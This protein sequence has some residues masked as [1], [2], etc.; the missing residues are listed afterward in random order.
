MDWIG[1]YQQPKFYPLDEFKAIMLKKYQ[2]QWEEM[3]FKVVRESMIKRNGFY[4]VW[5]DHD[6]A[7]DNSCGG[8]MTSPMDVAKKEFSRNMFHYFFNNCSTNQP[9][10][11]YAIDTPKARVIFLDNRYYAQAPCE[12]STILGEAQFQYV[13]EKLSHNLEYTILCGGLT[14]TSGPDSWRKNYSKDLQRFS[15]LLVSKPKVLFL[16]GDI[17]KNE[18]I[19]PRRLQNGVFTPPQ[20][21]S[22]GMQIRQIF[23]RHNWALLDFLD[24]GLTVKF[25]QSNTVQKPLTDKCNKWLMANG[26]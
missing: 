4:G 11:Y 15:E 9:E 5:D 12:D 19:P 2:R 8:D 21:I 10:V 22:S 14:L 1:N 13:E 25:F 24:N 17:H 16:A 23:D 3:H 26:Y 6:F 7:W 18:F 20:I